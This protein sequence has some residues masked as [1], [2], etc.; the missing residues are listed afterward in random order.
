MRPLVR[1]LALAACGLASSCGQFQLYWIHRNEPLPREATLQLDKS[2]ADL[3]RCLD[4]LG[5]PDRVWESAQGMVLSY[6]WLDQFYWKFDVVL[7][8]T[9]TSV[10]GRTV[11]SYNSTNVGYDGAVLVFDN[12]Q[13]LKFVRF[14]KLNVLTR[15]LPK[16]PMF[17]EDIGR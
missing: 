8:G 7:Y 3:Q 9:D 15:D 13:K 16:R 6:G 10:D 2:D 12:A 14:G 1:L 17:V 11:F 5:A 4:T